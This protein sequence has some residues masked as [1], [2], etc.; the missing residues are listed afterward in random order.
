MKALVIA[1]CVALLPLALAQSINEDG[2]AVPREQDMIS[3]IVSQAI[4]VCFQVFLY[5]NNCC[6]RVTGGRF[7]IEAYCF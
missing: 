1:L 5:V 7:G 2:T 6:Y 3:S 4:G